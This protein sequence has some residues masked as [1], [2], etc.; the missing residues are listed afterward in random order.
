MSA[1]S[2]HNSTIPFHHYNTP[3]NTDFVKNWHSDISP[4]L[5]YCTKFFT[6]RVNTGDVLSVRGKQG[7]AGSEAGDL[8]QSLM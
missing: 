6:V 4:N 5:Q 1:Q 8:E 7:Q 2:K 3:Q